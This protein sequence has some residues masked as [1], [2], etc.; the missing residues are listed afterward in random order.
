MEEQHNL[1]KW[2]TANGRKIPI[3]DISDE[4]LVNIFLFL[5]RQENFRIDRTTEFLPLIKLEL[6]IRGIV[7]IERCWWRK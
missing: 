1:K 4:H 6:D 5:Q 7:V 2:V 3:E